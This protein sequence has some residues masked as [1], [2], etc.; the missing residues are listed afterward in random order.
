MS[1]TLFFFL[2]LNDCLIPFFFGVY[3][4]GL[5]NEEEMSTFT[6]FDIKESPIPFK[7][8]SNP[9]NMEWRWNQY[10]SAEFG[11]VGYDGWM[12]HWN[13]KK[14]VAEL[15]IIQVNRIYLKF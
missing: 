9:K 13:H 3:E 5:V 11:Q 14:H 10:N 15:M 2:N 8:T 7:Q 6:E 4:I 1:N 12:L